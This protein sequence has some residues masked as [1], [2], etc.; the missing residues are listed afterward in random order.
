LKVNVGIACPYA[1]VM[2]F[3]VTV[4][5][6]VEMLSDCVSEAALYVLLLFAVAVILHR[7]APVMVT[8]VPLTEHGCPLAGPEKLTGSLELDVAL[9]VKGLPPYC[10]LGNDPKVM[11]CDCVV[12]P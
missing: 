1:I 7:P 9:I 10:A 2:G 3:A 11:V 12:D 5:G 6:A 8:V 4:S